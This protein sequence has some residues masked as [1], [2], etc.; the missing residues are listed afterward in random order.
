V[1]RVGFKLVFCSTQLLTLVPQICLHIVNSYP[2]IMNNY[3]HFNG[4]FKAQKLGLASKL[5][6]ANMSGTWEP[7][8][9][10]A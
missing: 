8:V 7:I 5:G 3:P 6:L 4:F 2:I 9:N 10:W 1:L